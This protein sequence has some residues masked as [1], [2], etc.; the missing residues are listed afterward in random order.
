MNVSARSLDQ[1]A[2]AQYTLRVHL[3][4]YLYYL[5]PGGLWGRGQGGG[6]PFLASRDWPRKTTGYLP[7]GRTL[8]TS[9]SVTLIRCKSHNYSRRRGGPEVITPCRLI[10]LVRSRTRATFSS[11]T[12]DSL[13]LASFVNDYVLN[14]EVHSDETS[15]PLSNKGR[16]SLLHSKDPRKQDG[17]V[18]RLQRNASHE[19]RDG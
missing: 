3:E 6:C 15:L 18:S 11:V 14:D 16:V 8:P 9:G 12:S 7:S 13:S 2:D 5:A 4:L 17:Q 10:F 19:K 1:S